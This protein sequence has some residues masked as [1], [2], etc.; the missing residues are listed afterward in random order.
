MKYKKILASLTTIIFFSTF[1]TGLVFKTSGS[2]STTLYNNN[3]GI[4]INYTKKLVTDASIKKVLNIITC[5]LNSDGSNII[6]S[7]AKDIE[8]K[9][10]VLSKQVQREEFK[11]NN[12]VAGI[13]GDMF[14]MGI[15]YSSGP[16]IKDGAIITN[17]NAKYEE[18]V[19]PVFGI[20]KD[21]KAFITF[22]HMDAK[23]TLEN[24]NNGTVTTTNGAINTESTITIDSVNRENC[25]DKLV[26]NNYQ[27]N[28]TGKVDLTPYISK[29]M[30]SVTVVKGITGPIKVGQEYI[31]TVN[32]VG[33]GSKSAVIPKD[34]ILLCGSGTK[35]QWM[36]NHLKPGDKVK[37]QVNYDKDNISEAIGAYTYFL[38]DGKVLTNDE[39]I[40]NGA[41]AALVRA[42]K[43]RTAIG[44]TADNKV[45]AITVDGGTPSKGISDGITLFEM[46]N[47]LKSLGAVNGVGMDGG[48]SAEMDAKLYGENS[49]NIITTPSD[50]RERALTNGV[51]FVSNTDR[52]YRVL[53][54][55]IN[56]DINIYKNTTF[57]FKANG[58]DT[59][60]NRLDLTNSSVNWSVNSGVGKIDSDGLFTSG[61]NQGASKV[62]AILGQAVASS[63]IKVFSDIPS[64]KLSD[65]STVPLQ[66]GKSRQFSLNARDANG[67]QIIIS[68]GA[69]TWSVTGDIGTIDKNGILKVTAKYGSGIVSAQVG[70]KKASVN[71][72]IMQDTEIIDDF[73]HNDYLG[74]AV[75]G[76]IGGSGSISK[77]FAKSGLCS[78]KIS[79]DYDKVWDRKSN[80]TINLVP[81]FFGKDANDIYYKYVSS[82]KPKKL[83]MWIYGDGNA[84]Q[85]EATIIDG[86]GNN[87]TI[88]I[89]KS[90]NWSGWK[91]VDAKIPSDISY[92]VTLKSINFLE[93]NKNLHKKGNI[94]FD[95]IQYVY[96]E[97]ADLKGPTLTDFS[98]VNTVYS[99]SIK[100]SVKISDESG[101]EKNGI[102]AKLDGKS[103]PAAFDETTGILS[104]NANNLEKGIHTFE[105]KAMDGLGNSLTPPYTAKFTVSSDSDNKAPIISGLS[106]S[107]NSIVKTN[108]PR[109]S[110]NVKD[111][112]VGVDANSI[113]IVL[114]GIKLKTYFDELSGI[115]SA[116][117]N[118]AINPGIHKLSITA[119]D[120]AGNKIGLQPISFTVKPLKQPKDP[121]NF[122]V[123]IL[124]DS[125]A[126]E[127]GNDFFNEAGIDSSELVLQN[128]GLIDSDTPTQWAEGIRQIGLIKNKP[129]MASPGSYEASSG[130]L[131][132]FRKY[133][134]VPTYSF[135]FGNSLF[136]SLNSSIGH[137]I[138][139]S[140]PTQFDYLKKVLENNKKQNIFIYT[141]FPTR[142]NTGINQALPAGD[143]KKLEDILSEYKKVNNDKNINVIFGHLRSFQSWEVK[144]VNYT[145]DGN[146]CLKSYVSPNN[147]GY[148]GYT[149]FII[150]GSKVIRKFVPMPQSIAVIDNS[151]VNGDMKIINGTKKKLSLYGDFKMLSADYIAPINNIKDVDVEWES[152]NPNVINIS[153]DGVITANSIGYANIKAT[154]QNATYTFRVISMEQNDAYISGFKL[155]AYSMST[156]PEHLIKLRGVGYDIYG[157]SFE[158][159]S[160]LINWQASKG[161]IIDGDYYSPSG[162]TTSGAIEINAQYKNFKST[163]IIK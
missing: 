50:G 53:N 61:N 86:D 150:N 112:G 117:P 10:E 62:T 26:L 51:I 49:V 115:A 90:I 163:Y 45:I 149:K 142:D 135:G 41:K 140:D 70:S 87:K 14:D 157:D 30:S 105:V 21:K 55:S 97:T 34:G 40:K 54:I 124:S 42:R 131:N 103:V 33:F 114:D 120:R 96:S 137:S 162:T 66:M 44:I 71:V 101:V 28:Q 48:G 143:V 19:Y 94:Y 2:S 99:K 11:G 152:D 82:L 18:N 52:T 63:N 68:N 111:D 141:H 93:T 3:I 113:S 159:N 98:P 133:F 35:A 156:S 78:Y 119:A 123:S 39:M 46:A 110:L 127:F 17:H 13:N 102:W 108:T 160:N 122:S 29:G 81:S 31:G 38:R 76:S 69:A 145:I 151:I 147:G 92:P 118:E 58:M 7:K 153:Q 64:L 32:S 60:M 12:V 43:A 136:I 161:T 83:G 23:L 91:Y 106:P 56:G 80:G 37:I 59:N 134:G 57:K 65:T 25:K 67:K 22:I 138:T 9:E 107:N 126:T 16:Q 27:L 84:P 75:N 4:G 128:G 144:G 116:I 73:E 79:Y 8:K 72:A 158:I 125:N 139:I 1:T 132:N 36:N 146:E 154:V 20:D 155:E 5:D 95:D 77:D 89:A 47:L 74:Y 24:T 129:V 88:D 15:G 100:I 121:N 6:F 148:M 109:I 85:L 104:Y 130:S